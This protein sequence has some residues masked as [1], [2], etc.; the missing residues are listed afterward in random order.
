MTIPA[1]SLGPGGV[2]SHCTVSI[3]IAERPEPP[4]MSDETER[5]VRVIP[6]LAQRRPMRMSKS[7]CAFEGLSC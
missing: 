7:S 6:A 4:P 1:G 2:R 3:P 5:A